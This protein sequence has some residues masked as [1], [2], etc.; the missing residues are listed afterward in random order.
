MPEG[1]ARYRGVHGNLRLWRWCKPQKLRGV[2]SAVVAEAVSSSVCRIACYPREKYTQKR[3][4]LDCA[5]RTALGSLFAFYIRFIYFVYTFCAL[6]HGEA[7]FADLCLKTQ[8]GSGHL[9]SVLK[10]ESN[11]E[12]SMPDSAISLCI[13]L[14]RSLPAFFS[15]SAFV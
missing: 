5:C 2:S 4:S 12:A 1:M 13:R 14:A 11:S 3:L 8:Q 6:G 7:N 9:P 15:A 10:R